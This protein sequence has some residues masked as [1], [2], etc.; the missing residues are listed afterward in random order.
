[1]TSNPEYRLFD[2]G[3][4]PT[5]AAEIAEKLDLPLAKVQLEMFADN[6]IYERI[7]DSVRGMDV[8]VIQSISD[9]V[10][11]N[12]IKLMIFIDAIRRTS[13]K[14]INVIMPYFGYARSDRKA[15]SREPI[16]ARLIADMLESQGVKR[17]L[18]MDLHTGQVQGFFD[19]PVDHLLAMPVQT[20]Y[21]YERG[22]T[23]DDV[24]VVA[25]NPSSL[26]MV[27]RF[28]KILGAQWAL[29]DRRQD[30]DDQRTKPYQI[31]GNV[32]G[33]VALILDDM[34]DTGRSMV[35]ASEAIQA[36]GAR[37]IEA[38]ATHAVLSGSAVEL[39]EN[40][41]IERVV[42]TNTIEVPANKRFSKLV[43]LSV[44]GTFAAGLKRVIA[45]ESIAPVLLSPDNPE[46]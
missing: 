18:T 46:V 24:V 20:H 3:S 36:A 28:A 29:V 13:A 25:S 5:L 23:G 39:L 1:M 11:D 22:L 34:I 38:V 32:A 19:I 12:F 14:S 40:S 45:H 8:Y 17:M 30:E 42:V 4:N 41:P 10:N 7:E 26:K 9:P 33:K 27:Q 16:V 35:L 37:H 43:D 44:A 2:L 31:T 15:R 6:E 21:F